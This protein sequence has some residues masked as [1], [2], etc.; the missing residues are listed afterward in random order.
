MVHLNSHKIPR[1]PWYL[2][3]CL[4]ETYLF[5]YRTITFCGYPFQDIQL[6]L[7]FV[8]LRLCRVR[9]MSNPMTPH[10]QNTRAWHVHGLG[11][12]PFARRYLGN[13]GCFI[14]LQVLR[15]FTSLGSLPHPMYSGVDI[16]TSSGWVSPFGNPRIKAYLAA[17]R[18]LSQLVTSFIAF[19][20][21]GIPR[22][23]LIT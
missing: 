20:R 23:L 10:T 4:R 2:G 5:A 16:P 3:I 6:R 8:T 11:C 1:V 12:S 14:F 9:T 19:L 22:I 18:G 17:N 7:S 21:Q 13:R 15:W